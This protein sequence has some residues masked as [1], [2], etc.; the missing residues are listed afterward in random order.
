MFGDALVANWIRF[1]CLGLHNQEQARIEK[2]S[3]LLIYFLFIYI[4]F[5]LLR[6]GSYTS[7]T[8]AGPRMEQN[9]EGKNNVLNVFFDV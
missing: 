7:P 5:K 4:F 3:F 9:G 8:H 6:L 2:V 1:V